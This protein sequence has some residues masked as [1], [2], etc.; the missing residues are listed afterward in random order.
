MLVETTRTRDNN[1][2]YIKKIVYYLMA[3]RYF[4]YV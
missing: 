4:V 1:L 3:N 2:K